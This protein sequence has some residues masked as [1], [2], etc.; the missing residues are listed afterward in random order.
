VGRPSAK[1][2][3]VDAAME[4]FHRFGFQ[5]CSVEDITNTAKVPKGSFYNH[6]GSKEDLL[7]EVLGRY[8]AASP[9][10]VLDDKSLS[11]LKRLKKYF[12]Q[13]AQIFVERKCE[14]GCMFGNVAIE[15]ADHSEAVQAYLANTFVGWAELIAGV[16][17]EA[18]AQGELKADADAASLAGFLLSAWQGTLLRVRA[19]R[20][21]KLIKEFQ[22]IAFGVL[23]I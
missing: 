17:A 12:E 11:P 5:G 9:R 10:A 1:E 19:T 15:M 14:R 6:F 21:P 4:Q 2:Q 18:Q 3:I 16:I 13:F 20:D 23:L 8:R 22:R 7:L